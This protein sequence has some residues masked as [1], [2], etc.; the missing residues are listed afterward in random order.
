VYCML[1]KRNGSA[2]NFVQFFFWTTLYVGKHL[3]HWQRHTLPPFSPPGIF[4]SQSA[5]L[6]VCRCV[7]CVVSDVIGDF[8]RTYRRRAYM[9]VVLQIARLIDD[10]SAVLYVFRL[11]AK[12]NLFHRVS[13]IR[14]FII[15]YPL[16]TGYTLSVDNNAE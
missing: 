10:L 16:L 5:S 14:Q 4:A 3:S 1:R 12:F 7:V 13:D 9:V 6:C 11:A 2:L 15:T 8:S